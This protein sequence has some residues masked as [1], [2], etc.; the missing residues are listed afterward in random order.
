MN[1]AKYRLQ[2]FLLVLITTLYGCCK[3]MVEVSEVLVTFSND[4]ASTDT[5]LI[6]YTPTLSFPPKTETLII[7]EHN[8]LILSQYESANDTLI[9][10]IKSKGIS[11]TLYNIK[12]TTHFIKTNCPGRAIDL[13]S[14]QKDSTM[15]GPSNK[16][17]LK[18]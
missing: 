17:Q 7:G 8:P 14:F 11:D 16:I 4:F 13:V 5:V 15:Y 9:I 10:Q 12:T 2:L 18:Y 6:I 1:T 3:L